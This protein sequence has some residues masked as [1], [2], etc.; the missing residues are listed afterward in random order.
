MFS[1]D[2]SR[3]AFVGGPSGEFERQIHTISPDGTSR[4]QLTPDTVT[5]TLIGPPDGTKIS[6]MRYAFDGD[7]ADVYVMNADGIGRAQQLTDNDVNDEAFS[8]VWS[9]DGTNHRRSP[10][11]SFLIFQDPGDER[12]S[13]TKLI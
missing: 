13:G 6:F 7:D 10:A 11:S 4:V 5:S 2:G 9:P 8:R 3:I 1:P 12:R